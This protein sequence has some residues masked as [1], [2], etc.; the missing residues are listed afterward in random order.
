MKSKITNQHI[1]ITTVIDEIEKFQE[2][3]HMSSIAAIALMEI[4]IAP[5]SNMAKE[6]AMLTHE[7]SHAIK[8]ILEGMT[9]QEAI[10]KMTEDNEDE[11]D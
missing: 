2:K 8:N 10:D 11:E 1:N 7:I 9:A 3:I 6:K 5:K 4:G